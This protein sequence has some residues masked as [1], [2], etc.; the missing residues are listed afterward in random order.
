MTST[1]RP[2]LVAGGGIGGLAAALALARA[3]RRVRVLEQAPAFGEIGAGIQLAPNALR[4]LDT[5][6]VLDHVMEHA[7]FP[8]RAVMID[9]LTGKEIT[10]VD[11]GPG[12]VQRYGYRYLVVHRQDLLEALLQGCRAQAS[13]ELATG[14]TVQSFVQEGSGVEVRCADGTTELGSALIGA[15]GLRS[16]VRA[17][18][19]DDG[20][21]RFSG[22][23]CY[24]GVVPM[25]RIPDREY[26]DAMA[27]WVG[28]NMHLVQYPLRQGKLMNNVVVIVSQQYLRGDAN[29]GGWDEVESLF[30]P[31]LPRVRDMLG[32]IE[33]DRNWPL[34]DRDPAPNWSHDRVTLL[35]DA[36]HPTLQNM[37]QGACMAIEDAL[38]LAERLANTDDYQDAF[39]A[40]Q[41]DRYLRTARVQISA[42]FMAQLVHVGGGARDVRNDVLSRRSP[43]GFP[44]LD[45]LYRGP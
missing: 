11:L 21:P 15:D 12:F 37:A 39:R 44:E 35:G 17:Q 31:A 7:V 22:H 6:G 8:A 26:G 36:A 18:L 3:G 33:R 34:H 45:W 16:P 14:R 13:I 43:E 24:R 30:A 28:P 41:Q 4:V 40:Y 1:D 2:V 32:Y 42:R 27:L 9:A 10:R 29:Y 23:L 5:L 25:D 19:L 38:C 20:A